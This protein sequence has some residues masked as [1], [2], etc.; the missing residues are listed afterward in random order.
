MLC[1]GA[2]ESKALDG[3]SNFVSKNKYV[4]DH[5]QRGTS[6]I[7]GAATYLKLYQTY[8]SRLLIHV[9]VKIVKDG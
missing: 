5:Q 2:F 8:Y 6:V 3:I 4:L 1:A 7:S 9:D